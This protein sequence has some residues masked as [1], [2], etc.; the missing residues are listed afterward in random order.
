M[1]GFLGPILP[2]FSPQGRH[3]VP[4]E[5]ANPVQGCK[6]ISRVSCLDDLG[7]GN[8]SF[9][10]TLVVGEPCLRLVVNLPGRLVDVLRSFQQHQGSCLVDTIKGRTGLSGVDRAPVEVPVEFVYRR[11]E[12]VSF[13]DEGCV[14]LTSGATSALGC[15]GLD[16]FASGVRAALGGFCLG[17]GGFGCSVRGAG[18]DAGGKDTGDGCRGRRRQA[19]RLRISMLRIL[20]A[21]RRLIMPYGGGVPQWGTEPGVRKLTGATCRGAA[22]ADS[23]AVRHAARM[24][25]STAPLQTKP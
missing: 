21:P 5:V 19:R 16:L 23:L 3:L 13:V 15:C 9:A 25:E 17:I 12:L 4:D 1:H 24:R 8:A 6:E 18:L 20:R 2:R 11:L 14:D 7:P 10:G 22:D